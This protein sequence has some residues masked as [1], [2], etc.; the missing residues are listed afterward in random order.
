MLGGKFRACLFPL[1]DSVVVLT[2]RI[3]PPVAGATYITISV[4]TGVFRFWMMGTWQFSV[5]LF[6]PRVRLR[7][8]RACGG[9][10]LE[11]RFWGILAEF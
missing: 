3:S 11:R 6:L 9:I 2:C 5:Y 7:E 1:C 4:F 10:H 8:V